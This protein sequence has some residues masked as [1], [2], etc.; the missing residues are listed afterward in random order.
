[1]DLLFD[2]FT[3]PFEILSG[4]TECFCTCFVLLVGAVL[5]VGV[6]VLILFA[7]AI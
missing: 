6:A 1:M 5:C 3:M 2:L 7:G 4:G